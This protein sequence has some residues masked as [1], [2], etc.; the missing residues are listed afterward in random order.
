L[1]G[2]SLLAAIA[3]TTFAGLWYSAQLRIAADQ[4]RSS[5]EEA[6][7]ERADAEKQA[8]SRAVKFGSGRWPPGRTKAFFLA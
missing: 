5:A 8:T 4:S 7:R 1:R 6:E 2:V 3:L